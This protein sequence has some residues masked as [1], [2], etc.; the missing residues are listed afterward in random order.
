MKR[1]LSIQSTGGEKTISILPAIV[2]SQFYP[3]WKG[4][5]EINEGTKLTIFKKTY[6]SLDVI[7]KPIQLANT[8]VDPI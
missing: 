8:G 4:P 1:G 2:D 6:V 5:R 3:Y 7:L